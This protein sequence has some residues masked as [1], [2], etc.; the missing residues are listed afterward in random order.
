VLAVCLIGFS[1]TFQKA[2][3]FYSQ[4]L[5]GIWSPI[6][7]GVKYFE[8]LAELMTNGSFAVGVGIIAAKM[9]AWNIAPI[10]LLGGGSLIIFTL[11]LFGFKSKKF[12]E[13]FGLIGMAIW[14]PLTLVW[15][16]II[17]VFFLRSVGIM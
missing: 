16:L 5:V 3:S 9:L 15:S 10:G 1:D 13:R 14:L 11:E 8:N 7:V 17:F 4:V 6:Q 12:S 2:F